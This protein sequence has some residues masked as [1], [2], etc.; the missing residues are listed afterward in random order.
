MRSR[1]WSLHALNGTKQGELDLLGWSADL[2]LNHGGQLAGSVSLNLTTLDGRTPDYPAI[3]SRLAILQPGLNSVVVTAA[4]QK[5]A[6]A[7]GPMVDDPA[8]Q[9]LLGEYIL[10]S[11][12]PA[13]DS[14]MLGV[15]GVSWDQYPRFLAIDRTEKHANVDAGWLAHRLLTRAF[16]GSGITI[17]AAPVAGWT[18]DMDREI[19]AGQ[20]M[21]AIEEV[22]ESGDGIEWTIDV[23]P[24]WSDG[25]LVSVTRSLRWGVP[26]IQRASSA[27][28]EAPE[29]LTNAGNCVIRGGGEDFGLYSRLVYGSGSGEGDKQLLSVKSNAGLSGSGYLNATST[30]SFPEATTQRAVD[31]LTEGA[32]KRAQ[33]LKSGN[34]SLPRDPY[35][36]DVELD[37]I[38]A[39]PQLGD[40]VRVLH[41]MSW[42]HPGTGGA[43]DGA[44]A[45]DEQIRVG[46]IRYAAAANVLRTVTVKAA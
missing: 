17:P 5:P 13:S 29:P 26:T 8:T 31:M 12:T 38:P 46:S 20:W 10:T 39:R 7:D 4:Q 3:R 34:L 19:G 9:A 42:A 36:V 21:D 35:S 18:V 16:T 37:L 44:M 22:C 6:Y 40:V 25:E 14:P 15:A 27:V 1:F 2:D 41:R 32:L 43:R 23:E 11:T 45:I 28:Y 30:R 24:V 33:G